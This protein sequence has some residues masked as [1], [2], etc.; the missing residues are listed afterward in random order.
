MVD[1]ADRH[2]IGVSLSLVPTVMRSIAALAPRL[3]ALVPS[4]CMHRHDKFLPLRISHG[5]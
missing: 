2:N 3:P 5:A 1:E 4:Q